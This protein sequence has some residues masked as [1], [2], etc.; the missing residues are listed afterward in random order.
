[1]YKQTMQPSEES[2]G[3]GLKKRTSSSKV[4]AVFSRAR[5]GRLARARTLPKAEA[6]KL[7][8]GLGQTAELR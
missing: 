1:V 8:W 5:K 7:G 3:N 2:V 6:A 4:S